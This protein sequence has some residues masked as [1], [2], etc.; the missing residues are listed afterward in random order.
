MRQLSELSKSTPHQELATCI[1]QY[2]AI[3]TDDSRNLEKIF[4]LQ[5]ISYLLEASPPD[6]ELNTWRKL[7]G[8]KS[9]EANFQYYGVLRDGSTLVKNI[10]FAETVCGASEQIEMLSIDYFSALQKRN[11]LLAQGEWT[12]DVATKYAQYNRI[13][14]DY[15][16]NTPEIQDK[17]YRSQHFLSLC[18]PK[19]EAIQGVV[20]QD[21]S[22]FETRPLGERAINNQNFTLNIEGEDKELVIRV[23][24]RNTM[25]HEQVLQTYPVSEY[26]SEEYF[27]MMMPFKEGDV[28][29]YKPLVLSEFVEKGSLENY[30][31]SL[32]EYST[33]D[34]GV[35]T[36][37]IFYLLSDFCIK[38]AGA[39]FYHP[40]IKLSNFLTDGHTIKVSDRKTITNEAEP[41]VSHIQ[42]TSSYAPP[43]CRICLNMFETDLIYSK[44]S[45]TK[46][47][48]NA[49]MSYELGMALKEFVLTTKQCE[50]VTPEKFLAW[51][52]F[53]TFF[54]H[55]DKKHQNLFTLIQELTRHNPRDRLSI[56]NFQTL[57]AQTALSP[58]TFLKKLEELSPR[59][60]LSE[61]E[62]LENIANVMFTPNPTEDQLKFWDDLLTD[63][64]HAQRIFS[65]PRINFFKTAYNEIHE[66]LNKINRLLEDANS[67]SSSPISVL[68]SYMIG[69]TVQ[70]I[71]I[72]DLPAIPI[73]SPKLLRYFAIFELIPSM[74]LKEDEKMMLEHIYERQC[75]SNTA[76]VSSLPLKSLSSD[77]PSMMVSSSPS[78]DNTLV[79]LHSGT[80]IRKED[81]PDLDTGT[82]I[83]KEDSS[84]LDTGTF[85][86]KEDSPDLCTGTFIRKQIADENTTVLDSG[87][88][89]RHH[90]TDVDAKTKKDP[91]PIS[92]YK[93]ALAS[94][95]KERIKPEE[96]HNV[97]DVNSTIRRGNKP[98]N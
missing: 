85:I 53:S 74:K 25:A 17:F 37:H 52:H 61:A 38:L 36:E 78:D 63:P 57:L 30:A 67:K 31:M 51:S 73:M 66:Y 79:N 2:N 88:V 27:A 34:M 76:K 5:R 96:S 94:F 22:E 15:F 68:Q 40:D 45:R 87:T 77:G 10:Q 3:D 4:L 54:E 90:T 13:I 42:F 14:L 33:Y 6:L 20:N 86:R 98:T 93:K 18:Y 62:T 11:E 82:F 69:A 91:I 8:S 75:N 26:F 1:A 49:V 55:L 41:L 7:R 70:P 89:V 47:D 32:S 71:S 97:T 35:E 83:R 16:H 84:Y 19:L 50:N 12:P 95:Q 9:L 48:M 60:Q 29:E 81:S 64:A 80:F 92:G 72:Q 24:D 39:G 46:V 59:N 58:V 65:D 28:V 21:F 44:A 43:E 23:E 56:A